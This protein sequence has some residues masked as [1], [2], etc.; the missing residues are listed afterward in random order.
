M[1]SQI[2]FDTQ[3]KISLFGEEN[4]PRQPKLLFFV[5]LQEK[6]RTLDWE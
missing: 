1:Q 5:T 2:T 4:L 6:E 3:L